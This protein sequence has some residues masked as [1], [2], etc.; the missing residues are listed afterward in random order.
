MNSVEDCIF[1][2]NKEINTLILDSSG[3]PKELYD[4]IK[5]IL[6]N[7]GKRVRAVMTL[8]SANL[9]TDDLTNT[10]S[11]ATG[12]E[13]FH[14]F[15]LLHDDIM[16]KAMIR[17][18]KPTVHVKW[19]D[20]TAIL[21]GDAMMILANQL[22]LKT[23]S[24]TLVS[25]LDVFNKTA[26]EVCEGQQLDMNLEKRNLSE[27]PISESEYL[28]MITL[29]TSVLIGASLKIGALSANASMQDADLLYQYG[30]NIGLAFQIQDDLLDSF[31]NESEF[32]KRI[33]GDIVEGKKTYLLIK[34]Y[35]NASNEDKILLETIINDSLIDD[36]EKIT[37]IKAIYQKLTIKEI[38]EQKI[39]EYFNN[40]RTYL[41]QIHISEE[42]LNV[43]L[44]LENSLRKRIH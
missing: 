38:T 34:A 35:E 2:I 25:I 14:N 40:A 10:I 3:E 31:G 18:G 11:P 29:K 6:S 36:N 28:Q 13:V 33:G 4:P 20:N 42:K 19:D 26:L 37:N 9:F 16:D 41:S 15:T 7:G 17:R 24:N 21:S 30:L 43:L 1:L 8:I 5:Y 22:L 23:K 39:E 44:Q 32:G 27:N 12:L